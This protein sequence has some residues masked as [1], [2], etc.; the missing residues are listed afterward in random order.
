EVRLEDGGQRCTGRVEVKYQGQWGTVCGF[1]WDMADAAVV[2]KQLGCGSALK[3][4]RFRHFPPGSVPVW[5]Y[6]VSCR[7]T[8]SALSDCTHKR[9]GK[10]PCDH[11]WDAGM[12]C[13]ACGSPFLSQGHSMTTSQEG[14]RSRQVRLVNGPGRC[15]G[16]VEIYYQG[17]WG[18]VCDDGWELSDATVVCR[19][20]GCGESW[21]QHDCGHKESARFEAGSDQ[22]WLDSVNCSGAEAALWDCPAESWGQHDCGHKEDAGVIC[23]G[24]CQELWWESRA[25]GGRDDGRD[26][27]GWLFLAASEPLTNPVLGTATHRATYFSL[28]SFLPEFV[29]LRLENSSNCSG[30]LQ[31]FYNGTWGSICS[32]SMTPQTVSLAC[33]ELGCGD[34]GT[35]ETQQLYGRLS[36]PTWL[37]YV[38]CGER[39]SSFWQCPSAPWNPQSCSDL[40]DETHITCDGLCQLSC[41]PGRSLSS[42]DREKIRAVGGENECSGRV[43]IWH[44]GSWGTVC[45]DSWDMWDAEVACRQ[46]G[47]GPAVS[48]LD[49][50][51][52]G[53]GTGPIWLEQVECRGT[54]PSLQDCWVRTGDNGACQHKED[55]AVHC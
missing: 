15:A 14:H 22:I 28:G 44:R 38:Q 39:N 36:D 13:S 34:G 33:K 24:L 19:Q 5:M 11:T 16:R 55:A 53:E 30:H 41:C 46:L 52:F 1:Y 29:A 27:N 6:K 8:E 18:T 49:K 32:N 50:A 40:R 23:S 26:G 9:Q 47:C 54:E 37:D 2:C 20:L 25:Q 4:P 31:V 45:D 51:A 12:I 43:E 3:A 48:A 42:P 21:G 17:S 35:L 10:C 7:G